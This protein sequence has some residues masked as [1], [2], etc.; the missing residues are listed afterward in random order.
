M[1]GEAVQSTPSKKTIALYVG[2][3]VLAAVAIGVITGM[4]GVGTGWAYG[5]VAILAAVAA[6][7]VVR[8]G[9][10]NKRT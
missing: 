5:I 2:A 10:L 7:V 4:A 1:N 8:K 3:V 9:W 6:A